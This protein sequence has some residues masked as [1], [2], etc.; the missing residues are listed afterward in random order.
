MVA[1]TMPE[2]PVCYEPT[3]D[4][5]RPC[6]HALCARCAAKWLCKECICPMCRGPVVPLVALSPTRA[7]RHLCIQFP[8]PRQ[9]VGITVRDHPSGVLVLH[10]HDKDRAAYHGLRR[11]DVITHVNGVS[12]RNHHTVVSI[13][14]LASEHGLPLV[15]SLKRHPLFCFFT[16]PHLLCS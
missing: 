16:T 5:V 8:Q 11:G 10:V 1:A 2:C 4:M 15:Y 12:V 14:N 13:T 7:Q 6:G 3:R 9:H